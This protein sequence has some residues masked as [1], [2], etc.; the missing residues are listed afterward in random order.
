MRNSPPPPRQARSK[1]TEEAL[2]RALDSLLA[3]KSFDEMS[4]AEIAREAG[5]TTGAV[6]RRFENKR[7]MLIAAV[8]RGIE[9]F[10][11]LRS[12]NQ[13]G[14]APALADHVLLMNLIRD[15]F[16]IMFDNFRILKA[17]AFLHDEKSYMKIRTARQATAN[18]FSETLQTSPYS[19]DVLKHKVAFILRSATAIYLDTLLPIAEERVTRKQYMEENGLQMDRLFCELHQMSCLYLKL[20]ERTD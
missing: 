6:Y 10:E 2:L 14:Y 4:V 18:W 1:R 5:L 7:A 17:V 16:R 20:P 19:G 12:I 9:Q 8:G 3:I 13:D 11:T 15:L